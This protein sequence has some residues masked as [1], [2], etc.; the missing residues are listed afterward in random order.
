MFFQSDKARGCYYLNFK[1][2][3]I[4]KVFILVRFL[5]LNRS[6]TH[7]IPMEAYKYI[8]PHKAIIRKCRLY[9]ISFVTLIFI[10]T[11]D[12]QLINQPNPSIGWSILWVVFRYTIH[13]VSKVCIYILSEILRYLTD[14]ILYKAIERL[15]M[16]LATYNS[17]IIQVKRSTLFVQLYQLILRGQLAKIHFLISII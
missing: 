12:W 17:H 1:W 10:S 5:F 7:N 15:F 14:H 16:A 4:G 3:H 8:K 9:S 2:H 6:Y 13:F 11:L